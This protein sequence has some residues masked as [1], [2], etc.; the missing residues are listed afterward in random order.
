MEKYQG[1]E[2]E[3]MI[4]LELSKAI[5]LVLDNLLDRWTGSVDDTCVRVENDAEW[6]AVSI[7]AVTIEQEFARSGLLDSAAQH[8]ELLETA[9]QSLVQRNVTP[10][11][12]MIEPE[13]S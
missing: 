4:T 11:R 1:Y 7:L 2:P 5:V 13:G 6:H 9:Q 8:A 3:G 12:S 10:N